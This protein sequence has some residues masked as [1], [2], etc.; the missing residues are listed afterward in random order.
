[1][2]V[3]PEQLRLDKSFRQKLTNFRPISIVI[4]VQVES[5]MTLLKDEDCILSLMNSFIFVQKGTIR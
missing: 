4:L 1:M 5:N 2:V 3:Q